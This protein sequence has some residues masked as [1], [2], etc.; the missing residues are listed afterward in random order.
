MTKPRK[1]FRQCPPAARRPSRSAPSTWKKQPKEETLAALRQLESRIVPF[2]PRL[3][4][5]AIQL[6]CALSLPRYYAANGQHILVQ[7]D[8]LD[9]ALKFFVEE[10]VT[11]SQEK[12]NQ[13]GILSRLGISR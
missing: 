5:R 9:F 12:I 11:R 7:D 6:A 10:A 2:S 13:E 8:A 4:R 1:H 3:E